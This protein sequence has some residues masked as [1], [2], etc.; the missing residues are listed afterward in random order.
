[1]SQQPD[2]T[3]GCLAL[4]A[5]LAAVGF[6]CRS[7]TRYNLGYWTWHLDGAAFAMFGIGVLLIF[8]AIGWIK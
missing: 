5:F 6:A 1:M 7:C 8:R 3:L 4:A 2:L